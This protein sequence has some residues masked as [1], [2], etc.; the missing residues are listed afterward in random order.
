MATSLRGLARELG[1]KWSTF[2][3]WLKSLGNYNTLPCEVLTALAAIRKTGIAF[4]TYPIATHTPWLYLLTNV[5]RFSEVVSHI[6]LLRDLGINTAKVSVIV[7]AGVERYWKKRCSKLVFDYSDEYWKL[8]WSAVDT[9]KSL[10][11]EFWCFCEVVIP[12]YPDDY[13]RAWGKKHCLWVD[14]YTNVDRTLE[15]VFYI[16]E[17]DRNVNWV[18]PAQGYE[19]EPKS[20]LRSLEVYT[21]YKLHKRFRIGIANLCTTHSAAGIVE[22]LKLAHEF[23]S[24]C[25]FHVF[26][27]KLNAIAKAV[28]LGY[29]RR[30]DSWDSFAWTFSRGIEVN[31]RGKQKYSAETA[32]EREYLFKTYLKRVTRI[33]LTTQSRT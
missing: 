24:E 30:G 19:D 27:P 8:F 13:S 12:D 1:F 28:K 18:L 11:R 3:Q 21:S 22:T 32:E 14:N 6:A 15:N 5:Y 26:G 9:V 16:I 31:R 20:I 29:L 2:I 17:Q 33:L 25:R 4:Y 23:C 10:R 7:D